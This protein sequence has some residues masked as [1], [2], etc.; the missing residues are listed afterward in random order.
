MWVFSPTFNFP[1]L[2]VT[3]FRVSGPLRPGLKL[4]VWWSCRKSSSRSSSMSCAPRSVSLPTW[5][6]VVVFIVDSSESINDTTERKDQ[7]GIEC[8]WTVGKLNFNIFSITCYTIY[9][10]TVH[11]LIK[12]KDGFSAEDKNW[13]NL[14]LRRKTYFLILF[15]KTIN[16]NVLSTKVF[17]LDLQKY[18]T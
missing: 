10:N 2:P 5:G 16:S 15:A 7:N 13:N 4:A 8:Y 18:F 12:R 3:V 1:T 6:D 9:S 17:Y 11:I 14:D